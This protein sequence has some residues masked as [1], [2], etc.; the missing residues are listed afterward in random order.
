[1]VMPRGMVGGQWLGK[2]RQSGGKWGH[3]SVNVK[4]IN[5]FFKIED[6]VS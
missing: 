4:N 1:M 2:H 3:P 5:K 6:F